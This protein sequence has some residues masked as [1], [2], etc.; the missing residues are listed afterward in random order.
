MV[1]W[2]LCPYTVYNYTELMRWVRIFLEFSQYTHTHTP[3]PEKKKKKKKQM[4]QRSILNRQI[5]AQGSHRWETPLLPLP[6]TNIGIVMVH[7]LGGD[8]SSIWRRGQQLS[9]VRLL[10]LLY[11][12]RTPVQVLE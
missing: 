10:Y 8:N 5:F 3:F 6:P 12:V 1:V 4:L 2:T 9:T 7:G 11:R